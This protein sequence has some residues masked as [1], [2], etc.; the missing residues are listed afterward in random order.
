LFVAAAAVE[1]AVIHVW[2]PSLEAVVAV[3]ALCNALLA[4]IGCCLVAFALDAGH[5]DST[6]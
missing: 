4:G 5:T 6:P 3:I 2:H 1:V